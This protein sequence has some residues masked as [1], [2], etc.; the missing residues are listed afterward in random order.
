M[1]YQVACIPI[2]HTAKCFWTNSVPG[3][4]TEE[5]RVTHPMMVACQ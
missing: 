2:H 5:S 3:K 4:L 1:G